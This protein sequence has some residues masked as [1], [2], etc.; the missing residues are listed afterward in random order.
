M[1]LTVTA[2]LLTAL[3][4]AAPMT[5]DHSIRITPSSASSSSS[6]DETVNGVVETTLADDPWYRLLYINALSLLVV[7]LP[8]VCLLG[9]A[10]SLPKTWT[11]MRRSTLDLRQA[12]GREACLVQ[13]LQ[14]GGCGG[15]PSQLNDVMNIATV[16]TFVLLVVY[17]PQVR[18]RWIFSL[19]SLYKAFSIQYE[20]QIQAQPKSCCCETVSLS[21]QHCENTKWLLYLEKL[22]SY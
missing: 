10:I 12:H 13:Q 8:L 3:A 4:Y 9:I 15:F 21:D 7:V 1:K 18:L 22:L 17:T 19:F 14:R 16:L 6:L 2:I 20:R 5:F 11:A